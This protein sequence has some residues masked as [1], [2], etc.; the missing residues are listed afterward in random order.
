MPT[1][2]NNPETELTPVVE[3]ITEGENYQREVVTPTPRAPKASRASSAK[4]RTIEELYHIDPK[5]MTEA[6]LRL[7]L[8]ESREMTMLLSN[9]L[10]ELTG[11]NN[12]LVSQKIEATKAYEDLRNDV[13]TKQDFIRRT[14]SQCN[15]T[16]M[17]LGMVK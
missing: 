13:L 12:S 5:K 11:I 10:E 8:T 4:T 3:P 2:N 14:V 16:I 15:E 1:R 9:K 7:A 17:R 6:E